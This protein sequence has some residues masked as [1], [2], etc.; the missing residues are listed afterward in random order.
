MKYKLSLIP[1]LALIITLTAPA[2]V[3]D[4]FAQHVQ[5]T[6]TKT[7][8][9]TSNGVTITVTTKNQTRTIAQPK[10]T[11]TQ[12]PVAAPA[13]TQQQP[14]TGSMVDTIPALINA[15]RQKAGLPALAVNPRLNESAATKCAHAQAKQYWGHNAPDGTTWH[16]FI[17]ARTAYRTAGENIAYGYKTAA[18]N[19]QRWI[20]SPGHRQNILNPKFTDVGHAVCSSAKYPNYVIQHFIGK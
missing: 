8:T 19:V 11:T 18:S 16:S 4:T 7:V 20:N 13:P 3:P 5:S 1:V 10:R 15:E 6:T 12:R 9:K 14:K 17:K 2:L